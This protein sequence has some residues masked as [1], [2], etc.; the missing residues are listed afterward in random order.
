MRICAFL[1]TSDPMSKMRTLQAQT[2]RRV[3]GG[4]EVGPR[5]R[6]P[7]KGGEKDCTSQKAQDTT[8]VCGA[9]GKQEANGKFGFTQGKVPK[10]IQ[11]TN[12]WLS[13]DEDRLLL[14]IKESEKAIGW[15][16]LRHLYFAQEMSPFWR[17]WI[18]EGDAVALQRFRRLPVN[19]EELSFPVVDPPCAAVLKGPSFPGK[20]WQDLDRVE[21]LLVRNLITCNSP[22]VTPL[23]V[24]GVNFYGLMEWAYHELKK[25]KKEF[26]PF[27]RM[28]GPIIERTPAHHPERSQVI[29]EIDWSQGK[30]AIQKAFMAAIQPLL[31]NRFPKGRKA[32]SKDSRHFFKGLVVL[33]RRK[34]RALCRKCRALSWGEATRIEGNDE[35]P[36]RFIFGKDGRGDSSAARLAMSEA[37][38][39]LGHIKELL[40]DEER[41]LCHG[42]DMKK[43]ARELAQDSARKERLV[44]IPVTD[45]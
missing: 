28:W 36:T 6:N 3:D 33:R 4:V 13:D 22:A 11:T 16:C 23:R 43:W 40:D 10:K 27:D 21:S 9:E 41:R 15:E 20:G 18:E 37:E 29:L 32:R 2:T 38:N 1:L 12:K 34:C 39:T 5:R 17:C 26:S 25:C 45:R 31:K 30:E 44:L 14:A 7:E 24:S 35:G 42:W 19:D 8:R